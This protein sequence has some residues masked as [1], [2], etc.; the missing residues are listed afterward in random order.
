MLLNEYETLDRVLHSV[1]SPRVENVSIWEAGNRVL[2][3]DVVATIALP[4]FD[5]STMDGYAVRAEDAV[6]GTRLLVCGEQAA[7]P[8]LGLSVGRGEAIRIYTGAPIPRKAD[9]VIMQEDVFAEERSILLREGVTRGENIR[10]RGGDLCEGQNVAFK[11]DL[12]TG[13]KL[14][15]IASQ[16][17]SQLPVFARPSVAIFA[18]GSELRSQG[19]P[20]N[21]GEIYETNRILLA[22]LV[23]GSGAAGEIFAIVPDLEEAHCKSF[24]QARSYDAIIVAGGVSVGAK[25]F[26][27]PALQKLGAELELWR[28][29]VKPGKPFMFGR[30]G[31]SLVFGLPG[32]PVS[33]FVT[34]LLFARPALW[35]L[36]GRS[37]LELART[38]ARLEQ[39][40]VNRDGRPHYF[41]GVYHQG[42]FK[43]VGKQ[44]SHALFALSQ[45]NAL[46]RLGPDQTLCANSLVELIPI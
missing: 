20:I 16:G 30:M 19:E 2:A 27:K 18:T 10:V 33:A 14:A 23:A 41:R 7:G 5:N 3:K 13:P 37:S 4:R 25:D 32:N 8:D 15:A 17:M 34:F 44:E 29:A 6:T 38:H 42:S 35:K 24:H 9:A 1:G 45:A 31:S 26:V 36:G 39:E 43:P 40:L 11:G 22:Q 12:L 46:C 28:V 21:A